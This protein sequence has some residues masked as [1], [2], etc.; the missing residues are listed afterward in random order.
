MSGCNKKATDVYGYK[1]VC[2]MYGTRQ[3]H[4]LFLLLGWMAVAA[5]TPLSDIVEMATMACADDGPCSA[6]FLLHGDTVTTSYAIGDFFT[7]HGINNE[8]AS[9]LL[10]LNNTHLLVKMLNEMP[11]DCIA[12][13]E[14]VETK[15]TTYYLQAIMFGL[16]LFFLSF[17]YFFMRVLRKHDSVLSKR[18]ESGG[19]NLHSTSVDGQRSMVGDQLVYRQSRPIPHTKASDSL[20]IPSNFR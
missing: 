14:V 1:Y 12:V 10:V 20:I 17:V 2:R 5:A 4:L 9:V 15:M 6:R 18:N 13:S 19:E 3:L 7:A 8:L 11:L 16:F